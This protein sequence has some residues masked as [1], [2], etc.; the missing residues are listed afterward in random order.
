MTVEV[1]V[2]DP[3]P[4]FRHGASMTLAEEGYAVRAPADLMAWARATPRALIL[5]TVLHDGDW[6]LLRR[7]REDER[8][9]PVI[10]VLDTDVDVLGVRAVRAGATSVVS[11]A[12]PARLL[13]RVVTATLE[14]QSV[15]PTAVV[16]AL[17]AGRFTDPAPATAVS[18]EQTAWL[19]ALAA[20]STVAD[21]AG[22]SGYSERAMFRLLRAVYQELGA[23]SK[24]EALIKAKDRGL[25]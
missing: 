4:M 7:L 16:T 15:L 2:V 20:G 19:R 1:A 21:L 8:G 9:H 12:A 23:G 3:L 5:L 11:R 6:A 22:R 14:G 18:K 25:L 13:A 24:V 17:A 10:A